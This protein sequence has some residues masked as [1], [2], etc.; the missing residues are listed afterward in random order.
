M[1]KGGK[2]P[3]VIQERAGEL[4]AFIPLRPN[5][6]TVLALFLGL[7]GALA[8]T[9]MQNLYLGLLLFVAGGAIDM[10]DG[11]VARA[12]KEATRFGGFL[13][14]VSDRF[15]EAV[16]LFAF[17]FYPLPEILIDSNIWLAGLVFTGTCMPSF[18]RAYAE[19]N[20]V[21]SHVTAKEMGGLF[22]RSERLM[23]LA[24]GLFAGIAL[25]MDY[26]VGA[27]ILSVVLS[28]ITV[29]QRMVYV[30][31]HQEK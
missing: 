3:K 11:A 10:V 8:I 25:S 19:H 7:M 6:W 29:L 31:H 15:M 14:G 22:E 26:F 16:F 27:V 18:I 21:I 4:F 12:R 30:L 1:L 17:M 2:S 28:S 13:D 9:L 23:L 24:A 20:K 5:H